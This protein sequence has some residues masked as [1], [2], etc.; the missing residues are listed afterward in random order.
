MNPESRPQ[1]DGKEK[2]HH[3]QKEASAVSTRKRLARGRPLLVFLTLSLVGAVLYALTLGPAAIPVEE[4]VQILLERLPLVGRYWAQSWP[5]NHQVI[6]WD[7]RL[8]RVLLSILVGSSLAVAGAAMQGLFRN[9]LADPY[10]LGVSAG[11]ALGASSAIVF[12]L[13]FQFFGLSTVPLAAFFGSLLAVFLVYQLGRT[14]TLLPV[15]TL[16]LAGVAVGSFF[17]ALTSLL[18]VFFS[19]DL[20]QV[21]FWLLGGFSGRGWTHFLMVLPYGLLGQGAIYYYSRELNLA[22]LGEETALNLGVEVEKVRRQLLVVASLTAA[23]SVAA[24]G[25]IG[26][27]GLIVPHLLRL[28]VGPDHRFLLPASAL[29]G[30]LFLL[31]ADTAARTLIPPTEIPVGTITAFFGAPFFLYLLRRRRYSGL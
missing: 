12:K 27:V 15:G 29:G 22:L 9:P 25:I 30:G 21:F 31:L 14:G 5:T 13:N 19:D 10:I 8:P 3:F 4:T 26:F 24:S 28:L 20:H 6:I 23:A 7:L 1:L 11:A 18:L 17:S 16:L 2:W